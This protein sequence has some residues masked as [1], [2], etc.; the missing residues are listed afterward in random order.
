V[1][2]KY[3][4]VIIFAYNTKFHIKNYILNSPIS[5]RGICIELNNHLF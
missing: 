5:R 1:S 4:F 2:M 3:Y